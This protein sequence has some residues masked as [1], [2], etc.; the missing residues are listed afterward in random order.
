MMSAGTARIPRLVRDYALAVAFWLSAS[1]LVA[2]QMYGFERRQ[3]IPVHLHDL[4]LVFAARYLTVAILTPPIFYLVERWPVTGAVVRRTAGYALG[5]LPFSC[6]FAV[7]RWLLLPPWLED[8]NSWG[9][10]SLGTLFELLYS[11]FADVLLLYLSVV[12][13]AH[14]Y[15]YFV[16]GQRHEIERLVL[17]QSL[18][19]SE[20]QAL[21]AQLHPHFLFNTLQGISTLIETDRVT[22]Q[23]MLRA[24]AALLRT[25]LK[26]GSADLV[27]FRE[28]LEFLKS[29]L[30]LEKMRLGK[31]LAV[32][33]KI[34]PETQDAQ[35][36]Q[37]LLQ[38]LLENALVHGIASS[39]E[40]GWIEVEAS[41]RDGRLQVLIRN[42]VGGRSQPG[43]GVGIA[44]ARARLKYLYADDAS[45]DFR[46][47]QDGA[48]AI[49][50]LTLPAFSTVAEDEPDE[51]APAGRMS[52]P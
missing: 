1:V 51:R 37:L 17:R 12:V 22:A 13:A 21:R 6:A 4:L 2:G 47:E 8:T 43:L 50:T 45:L 38:P 30:N 36:P 25:T 14:A 42:T 33:W 23:N 27:T 32:R 18:A 52:A 7:I 5:Y 48:I 20:L 19:Q 49:A 31:R 34:A 40:G 16:N 26:H 39:L 24:L 28:E 46:L 11:T 15:A 29:Y 41:V 44:N 10:R 9:P 3:R 35:I